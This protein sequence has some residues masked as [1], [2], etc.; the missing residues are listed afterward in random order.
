MDDDEELL[1]ELE[2]IEQKEF[3]E[4]MLHVKNAPKMNL[5]N[6]PKNDPIAAK[7]SREDEEIEKL[8][9]WMA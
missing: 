2:E 3:E 9:Q 8:Q 1:K 5:P 6:T 7:P 4:K